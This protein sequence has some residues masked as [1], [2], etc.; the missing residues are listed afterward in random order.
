MIVTVPDGQGP[1]A[2]TTV[3]CPFFRFFFFPLLV[4]GILGEFFSL[5]ERSQGNCQADCHR[6]RL[7]VATK[8]RR[9]PS[10]RA[11]LPDMRRKIATCSS[12]IATGTRRIKRC[13]IK[14]IFGSEHVIDCV[15]LKLQLFIGF[16]GPRGLEKL[17]ETCRKKIHQFWYLH[18]SMVPSYDQNP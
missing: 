4:F 10:K 2:R 1:L 13:R 8:T 17:R 9:V 15:I 12:D 11:A 16:L 6:W 14:S 5:T 3:G 7:Q 18:V